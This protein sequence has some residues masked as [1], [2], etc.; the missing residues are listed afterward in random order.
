MSGIELFVLLHEI[1]LNADLGLGKVEGLAPVVALEHDLHQGLEGQ[2]HLA[3]ELA[4]G[5]ERRVESRAVPDPSRIDRRLI[6][7][8]LGDARGELHRGEDQLAAASDH[9]LGHLVDEHLHQLH[10]L[11]IV[12]VLEVWSDEGEEV[13]EA[14]SSSKVGLGAAQGL[15]SMQYGYL[16]L[17][18]RACNA[19][20]G[21]QAVGHQAV[22]EEVAQIPILAERP[23]S[24]VLQI[25]DMQVSCQ[26]AVGKVWRQKQKVLLL[27]Y[28]IR[29]LLVAGL[30]V[31]LQVGVLLG[32]EAC[33]D[34]DE[35]GIEDGRP[36]PGADISPLGM[37]PLQEDHIHDLSDQRAAQVADVHPPNPSLH[38]LGDVLRL[39]FGYAWLFIEL[40]R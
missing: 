17:F 3:L 28:F 32:F 19:G 29:F 23:G 25:V 16:R 31:L 26:V 4:V 21:A 33:A 22:V 1:G 10:Y 20:L 40:F 37:M 8:E 36:H 18:G 35:M 2:A 30:S 39:F 7:P 11:F 24:E 12:A 38:L 6:P 5:L 15:D 14:L 27:A 13:V 9:H 34:V